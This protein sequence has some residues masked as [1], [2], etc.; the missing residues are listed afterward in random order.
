VTVRGRYAPSPTGD[1]HLG[2]ASTA[3]LAWLSARSRGGRFVMRIEDLDLPRVRPGAEAAQLDDLGWLGLDWDEGPDVGGPHAPYRQSERFEA[4]EAAFERLRSADR[5]Y[6]CFCS[7][8]DIAAAASAPQ[9]PGDEIR[10]PGTCRALDPGDARRRIA[11][12][13]PHA[14]R[15]RVDV[16]CSPR[17]DDGVHGPAGGPDSEPPGDFVV[18][19]RDG[20]A[21]YQLAVVVDDAAMRIDE[22]VRGDDLMAST[23][24]QQL[25]YEAFGS[26]PPRFAHVPLLCGPDGVRLS[27]RH[28]GTSLRALRD[29][30][31]SAERAVGWIARQVGLGDGTPVRPR[32]LVDGFRFDR[33]VGSAAGI[34]IEP[35]I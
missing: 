13:A 3:L 8:K 12:G 22:V 4:Y 19:R 20:T 16:S 17:F 27:K 1:V 30:G 11:S 9:E 23:A 31:W 24:R 33:V 6:P 5:C 26:P 25:L 10:Y 21:S 15:F 34:R 2:N 35:P 32:D 29:H 18:R 28:D 7:R 14:W